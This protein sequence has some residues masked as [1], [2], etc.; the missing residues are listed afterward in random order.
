[1][2]TWI[3]DRKTKAL[4]GTYENKDRLFSVIDIMPA[5]RR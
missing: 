2:K 3:V 4:G 1:M 5:S